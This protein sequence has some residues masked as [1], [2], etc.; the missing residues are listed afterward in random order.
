MRCWCWYQLQIFAILPPA[1][2]RVLFPYIAPLL[3]LLAVF[4]PCFSIF[5]AKRTKR[6]AYRWP[7]GG[8]WRFRPCRRF[9]RCWCGG[10]STPPPPQTRPRNLGC[11]LK[12]F[13]LKFY[14][15]IFASPFIH[16]PVGVVSS[17]AGFFR[18]KGAYFSMFS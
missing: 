11:L 18:V 9:F 10:T 14:F 6:A 17:F 4:W 15:F 5:S 12:K 16:E 7:R 3:V 8:W 2:P 1:L 13:F